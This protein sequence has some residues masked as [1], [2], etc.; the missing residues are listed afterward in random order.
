MT[1]VYPFPPMPVTPFPFPF[2]APGNLRLYSNSHL[3]PK[4]YPDSLPFPF[5]FPL[6]QEEFQKT[7]IVVHGEE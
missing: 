4:S 7:L 2:P 1:F 3:F 5:P 6:K